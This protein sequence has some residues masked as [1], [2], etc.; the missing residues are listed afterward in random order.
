MGL[1]RLSNFISNIKGYSLYVDPNNIDSTDSIENK[2]NSPT[3]PFKTL[4][5]AI[6][7][8][9]RYSYQ[10][11]F[12]NDR[13]ERTTIFLSPGIHIID[14]R[15]GVINDLEPDQN[16]SYLYRSSE[17]NNDFPP[18]DLS[19]NFNLEDPNNILYKINS[20]YG[21]VIIPRGISVIGTDL[22]K[23]K[24]RPLYVPNPENDNIERSAIFR[25]T[26][27]THFWGFTILDADPSG[28]CYKD[29]TSNRFLPNF[30]HHK[31]TAF[32]Y[33]DGVNSITIDDDFLKYSTNRTDLDLYYEKVGLAFGVPSGR[34]ISPDY[35]SEQIDIQ[36]KV[37]EYQIVG[38]TGR[39]V[40]ITSI[41]AGNG[42]NST[43][44]ITVD[45]SEPIDV[46]QVDTPIQ[47]SGVSVRGYSGQHIVSQVVSPTQFRYRVQNPPVNPQP[48]PIEIAT[49]TVNVVSDTVTS[50][51][52]YIFNV[53]LRSVFG[54]CGLHADGSKASGFKSMVVAQFTGIGLQKDN[55]AFVLFNE[56]TGSYQDSTSV[57]NLSSNSRARFK[58]SY[59]NYH[60]KASNNAFIQL[61]SIFAIG[62]AEHFKAESGGDLSITNS[63]SNFGAKSLVSSGFRDS[64]FNQDDVG[65]I[66]HIIAPQEI[67]E[68]EIVVE[69]NSI[70]VSLTSSVANSGRLYLLGETNQ[71]VLPDYVIDG[72]RIGAKEND[73]LKL[74]YDQVVYSS[75]II[76]G[77]SVNNISKKSFKVQKKLNGFNNQIDSNN[78]ITLTENHNF[79][80]GE[81]VRVLSNTGELPQG[82][83]SS[84]IYYV[85]TNVINNS[86]TSNQIKLAKSLNDALNGNILG[87]DI[88]IYSNE[89]SNLI[90][91][92]RVSDK[93]PGEIGHP[94]QWDSERSNWYINTTSTNEIYDLI[95]ETLSSI[96]ITSTSRTY[97]VRTPDNRSSID[98]L[99][100]VRYVIPK[101]S[102]IFARP[103][104]DGSVL[105]DSGSNLITN[106]EVLK[107]FNT[108][109]TS[110][111]NSTELRNPKFISNATWSNGIATITTELPHNLISG[112]EVRIDN[113][114]SS[115]NLTG[116]YN[117]GYNGI[118]KVQSILNRKQFTIS[119]SSPPGTFNI[120]QTINRTT[121][122][123]QFRR[124]R[125]NGTYLVYRSQEV[126]T[127][128]QGKQDGIYHLILV[129]TSVSPN[130]TPFTNLKF[131]QP[132]QFLYPRTNRDNPV[133]DPYPAESFA[134]PDPIGEVVIN[135]PE[136]SITKKLIHNISDDLSIGIGIT[137]IVSDVV[138]TSHTIY[139]EIDHG[140]NRITGLELIPGYAGAGYGSGNAGNLYNARLVGVGTSV[141]GDGATAVISIDSFG[142]I[143][144]IKVMDGG[145]AYGIGNTLSVVGVATTIGFTTAIVRVTSVYN[146]IGTTLEIGGIDSSYRSYNNL[147]RITKIETGN[148]KQIEVQSATAVTNPS[149][150]GIGVSFTNQSLL[151]PTGTI[152][153]ISS[154]V[155]TNTTGIATITSSPSHG[156][157]IDNK[158]TISGS[159]NN[160][161]NRE[162]IVKKIINVTTF[163]VNCGIST[164]TQSSSGTVV[165]YRNQISSKGGTLN[166]NNE[167]TNGRL[168]SDYAGIT[169]TLLAPIVNATVDNLTIN[170][171]TSLGFEVGDYLQIG[172]EIV[173]IERTVTGNQI[174]IFRG[175][176]GTRSTS[177]PLGTVVRRITPRPVE[178][179]RS[180]I[181]RASGHTFEYVGFGPG[182]YSTA[183]PDK[184]DRKLSIQENILAQSTK[185]DGGLTV[186]TGMNDAGDF[187][188][189]NKRIN[190]ST[191]QEEVFDTPITSFVGEEY[192]IGG[193]NVGFDVITPL[194]VSITRSITV[195]G[196]NNNSIISKFNGPVVFNNKITSNSPKGIEVTSLYLQGDSDISRK[197]TVGTSIPT[198]P[199]SLGDVVFNGEPSP[200][201]TLGWRYT[202]DNSWEEISTGGGG[203]GTIDILTA[204][205]NLGSS[206]S[207]NFVGTGG[208]TVSGTY[209]AITGI[210]TLTFNASITNPESL[211]VS[212]IATFNGP[213]S[214]NQPV[215]FNSDV[216]S[217]GI[218]TASDINVTN[219]RFVN[220]FGPSIGIATFTA[221][222]T[223]FSGNIICGN[224]TKGDDTFV[225]VLSG[226]N[227]KAGFEAYGNSQGTGY[228]YVGE[229]S[230]NGGG[231]VYNGNGVPSFATGETSDTVAF[232]RR[233]S[234]E[235]EVVFSY[236]LN[237]N[238]VSFRGN[239][240]SSGNITASG[241]IN[242]L[243]DENFKYNI[244]PIEGSLEILNQINGVGFN[245][246]STD[247]K[248]FGVIAQEIEKVLPELVT[249][250]DENQ[251]TVNYNGLIA[252]LIQS[253]KEQQKK[254]NILEEK[255]KSL[256]SR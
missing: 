68:N 64:A 249:T 227:A 169:T 55:K 238:D 203:D 186:F 208:I 19:S 65:Y 120:A 78:I 190:S 102:P 138:G 243:S 85:I 147:Y 150:T 106:S 149:T 27:A 163:E 3:R 66:T 188:I 9:V 1:S 166:K 123:P 217:V 88:S 80:N 75:P 114:I 48:N 220:L 184:Q 70:D 110:L 22:R 108:S 198:I 173:R 121:S 129:D 240:N 115:L 158:I 236:S 160:F 86:L 2:G 131:S 50:A 10:R 53:S 142:A 122:L 81:S 99:Y 156:L 113:V 232:Y 201:E 197:Y 179:R 74:K 247:K 199:G 195:E 21:G 109:I 159:D 168:I 126:Q 118:F 41:R 60:I 189:G 44:T 46:L 29:Y 255:I 69:Y 196:G 221:D 107:Y 83:D 209:S 154:I 20:I 92:S 17:R 137:N 127:Y 172:N 176:L 230:S 251:K 234:N 47:I 4:Q 134:S 37:D 235:N 244:I 211:N 12:E 34:N 171:A 6:I 178:F 18:F 167:S 30:S 14:N 38:S 95:S 222:N 175:V 187:Y 62:Y 5:R 72:Y 177:H 11:G 93:I 206:S 52:P 104:L 214:F 207:I 58:P 97:I 31:L 54:M 180:S 35:P 130:I 40:G 101:D 141:V 212:G 194:E 91:E 241:D 165:L 140:F 144:D 96:P 124:V 223:N 13:F 215:R 145:S 67:E 193:M 59:E 16:P 253:V 161:F 136:Y 182:N 219:L 24:I 153:G 51:S 148:S 49:A 76:M 33:V 139:T 117:T 23:T 56:R 252:I 84:S 204:G 245:W 15:P 132:I 116:D 26:G 125:F 192:D 45:I 246:K 42:I 254:I 210:S 73:E 146:D 94:I 242:S 119:I 231:I 213:V 225:R 105:Q 103:P 77:G 233:N 229:S 82:I 43:N 183:L 191:G 164:T 205:T 226:D 248:S 98:T 155:Y 61:V 32:E 237:N 200:G 63:N 162:F 170:N 250:T 135:N 87:T 181:I 90:I 71:N 133:S 202:T 239:L 151:I 89:S 112:C 216:L 256:E 224:T 157:V 128:I 36:A 57:T 79:V 152:V 143:T 28:Y 111:N 174:D 8:A 7:E 218:L 100:R 25:L 39:E 185:I 228:L